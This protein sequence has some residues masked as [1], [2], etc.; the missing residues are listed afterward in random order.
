[1]FTYFIENT[2]KNKTIIDKGVFILGF[3]SIW[4]CYVDIFF[5][6]LILPLELPVPFFL[7]PAAPSGRPPD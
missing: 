6:M 4:P 3:F 7:P 2:N 1:V 5:A